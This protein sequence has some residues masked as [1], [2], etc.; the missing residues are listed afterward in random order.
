MKF[1]PLLLYMKVKNFE[2][3]QIMFGVLK[4]IST[5]SVF[6]NFL[7]R[8]TI[9]DSYGEQIMYLLTGSLTVC[10]LFLY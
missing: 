5:H 6:S 4:Y 1:V 8:V 7:N 3:V 2:V 9:S 10:I